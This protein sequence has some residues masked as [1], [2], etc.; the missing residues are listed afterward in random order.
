[1]L[2]GSGESQALAIQS[3]EV[4]AQESSKCA[5]VRTPLPLGKCSG[6]NPLHMLGMSL[7]LAGLLPDMRWSV[8]FASVLPRVKLEAGHS[9]C[10]EPQQVTSA[11][12]SNSASYL[13]GSEDLTN[14][15]C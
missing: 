5:Q 10:W 1:M 4:V 13:L 11:V 14:F 12:I 3:G 2:G 8:W 15:L 7:G 6:L 9:P